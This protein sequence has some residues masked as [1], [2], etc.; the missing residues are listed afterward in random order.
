MSCFKNKKEKVG[1]LNAVAQKNQPGITIVR[2]PYLRSCKFGD[3][4]AKKDRRRCRGVFCQV[5]HWE[6]CLVIAHK[7]QRL[8]KQ[9]LVEVT[10]QVV[11]HLPRESDEHQDLLI[12]LKQLCCQECGHRVLDYCLI[13]GEAIIDVKCGRDG[14]VSSHTIK[15]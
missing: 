9:I 10:G 6:A 15:R 14:H 11:R 3:L 13:Y 5:N 7:C 4:S 2:C 12:R 1:D 8:R